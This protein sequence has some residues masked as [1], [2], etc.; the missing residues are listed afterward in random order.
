M[1]K[2][3]LNSKIEIRAEA[4]MLNILVC[5]ITTPI[6]RQLNVM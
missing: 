2:E 1:T 3:I 5:S 6:L 4:V